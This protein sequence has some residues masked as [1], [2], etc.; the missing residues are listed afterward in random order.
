MV[1]SWVSNLL[2]A[3]SCTFRIGLGINLSGVE[4][5]RLNFCEATFFDGVSV[6]GHQLNHDV[7]TELGVQTW[8]MNCS[9]AG[10]RNDSAQSSY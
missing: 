3:M 5:S 4:T 2:F 9:Q 10:L 8:S 7:H 6:E 1:L